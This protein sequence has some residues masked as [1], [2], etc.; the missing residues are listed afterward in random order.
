MVYILNPG[1]ILSR[2]RSVRLSVESTIEFASDLA[3][4]KFGR[5]IS[6]RRFFG[7]W[8]IKKIYGLKAIS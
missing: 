1:K 5:N 6:H 8:F 4:P 2:Y 7:I 3:S